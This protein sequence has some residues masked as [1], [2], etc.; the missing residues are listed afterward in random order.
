MFHFTAD[1]K[2]SRAT[3]SLSSRCQLMYLGTFLDLW[4]AMRSMSGVPHLLKTF[5]ATLSF[6][7]QSDTDTHL[8]AQSA[9]RFS[10]E[11]RHTGSIWIC[12]LSARF[13]ISI[14]SLH[15]VGLLLDP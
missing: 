7:D 10:S 2:L 4:V 12:R 5:L 13:R 8:E 9:R 14:A 1:D 6:K 15:R 3:A 11:E